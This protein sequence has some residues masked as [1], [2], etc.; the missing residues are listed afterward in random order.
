MA[1]STNNLCNNPIAAKVPHIRLTI[2]KNRIQVSILDKEKYPNN[3]KIPAMAINA[4]S[5]F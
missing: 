5:L 1:Q 4:L 3:N 2:C